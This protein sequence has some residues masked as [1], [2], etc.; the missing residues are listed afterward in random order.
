MNRTAFPQYLRRPQAC[1]YLETVWG[2][3]YTPGTLAKMCSQK[4]GP[5]IHRDG[6]RA[7]HT[8]Q[9]LDQW[10]RSRVTA[11]VPWLPDVVLPQLEATPLSTSPLPPLHPGALTQMPALR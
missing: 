2:L 8:P 1:Q 9:A 7:L 3:S 10:A 11:P 5:A 4:R 6:R